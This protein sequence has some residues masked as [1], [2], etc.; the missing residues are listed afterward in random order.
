MPAMLANVMSCVAQ[1]T[2]DLEKAWHPAL[3]PSELSLAYLDLHRHL[4]NP[5]CC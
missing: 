3:C 4:K 1:C 5:S 2:P